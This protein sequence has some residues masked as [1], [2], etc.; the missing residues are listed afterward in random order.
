MR[1]CWNQQA[2]RTQHNYTKMTVCQTYRCCIISF[3][4]LTW[5]GGELM[6]DLG[7]YIANF[8]QSTQ[9]NFKL[10]LYLSFVFF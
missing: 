5:K 10:I 2:R 3:D 1:E 6:Q 8:I 4:G 9:Q 7:T